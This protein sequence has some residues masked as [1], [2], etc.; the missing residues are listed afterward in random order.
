MRIQWM[1]AVYRGSS[2]FVVVDVQYVV[3]PSTAS[4]LRTSSQVL[5]ALQSHPAAFVP[6]SSS[7]FLAFEYELT[8]SST[9]NGRKEMSLAIVEHMAD[10]LH[11]TNLSLPTVNGS[12]GCDV[13]APRWRR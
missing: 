5:D 7:L 13:P 2:R 12:V 9:V 6:I 4:A 1:A 8:N 11:G 3:L 10:A